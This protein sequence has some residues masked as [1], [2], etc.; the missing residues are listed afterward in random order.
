[1]VK[2]VKSG[3]DEVSQRQKGWIELNVKNPVSRSPFSFLN[4]ICSEKGNLGGI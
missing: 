1:M 4:K 3:A 2:A